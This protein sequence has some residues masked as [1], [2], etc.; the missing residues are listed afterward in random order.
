MKVAI[1]GAAGRVGGTVA[2]ALKRDH[3]LTLIDIRPI[4]NAS[5]IVADLSAPLQPGEPDDLAQALRQT[6]VLV[7]LAE[8]PDPSTPWERVLGNNIAATWNVTRLAATCGVRRIVYASSHWAVMGHEKQLASTYRMPDGRKI[9]SDAPPWPNSYYGIAKVCGEL[10][11]KMLVE[12]GDLQSFV[13][14]RIGYYDPEPM[15]EE[16]HRTLGITSGDLSG[17]FRRCVVA[18][19]SGFHIVYGI[20]RQECGPFDLSYTCGL[21]DWEPTELPP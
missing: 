8:D 17:L 21:L 14:V 20:S 11:G 2:G 12:S 18:D 13:A 3:D 19:F 9:G 16:H 10:T 1:T 15:S 4:E 7:H 6:E 5:S